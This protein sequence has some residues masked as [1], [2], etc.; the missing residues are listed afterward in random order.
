M[1]KILIL[2]AN[3]D[4]ARELGIIYASKGFDLILAGRNIEELK[5]DAKNLSNRYSIKAEAH[6]FDALNI[7]I[8][9]KNN[10]TKFYQ[11]FKGDIYGA[12]AA[13]GYLG[14][15][16]IAQKDPVESSRILMTN[17]NGAVSILDIIAN[18]LEE[19][20][21]GF[22]IGISSVAGDRGR[23]SN[24]HYGSAKAGFTAY[25]SGLRNRLFKSNVHVVT[26]KPGFIKSKMTSGLKLPPVIT[27]Q[28]VRVAKDIYRAQIKKRNCV[29]TL[30][31]WRWL[32]MIVRNI[33]EFIFK[34]LST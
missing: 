22:I 27:A 23:Q 32:M 24:Y 6:A 19:K 1:S 25:L 31:H 33:P 2:G 30:W 18:D 9:N 11:K 13:F 21:E 20:S 29:Y 26:V 4:V 17:F 28:P 5:L 16:N 14:D 15:A 3:S 34:R 10:H 8:K 12:I 7:E